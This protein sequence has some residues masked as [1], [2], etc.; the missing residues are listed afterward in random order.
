MINFYQRLIWW[1]EIN[2][3]KEEWELYKLGSSRIFNS[4]IIGITFC[5]VIYIYFPYYK[6][7]VLS[8]IWFLGLVLLLKFWEYRG[9]NEA[10]HELETNSSDT[11]E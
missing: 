6:E 2:L 11:Y 9:Y 7:Y 5:F 10:L 1:Y 3:H 8:L 4:Y